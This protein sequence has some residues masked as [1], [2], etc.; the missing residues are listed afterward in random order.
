M[1]AVPQA[2]I[3]AGLLVCCNGHHALQQQQQQQQLP[4]EL[5]RLSHRGLQAAWASNRHSV[6]E[7]VTRRT[8]NVDQHRAIQ[9]AVRCAMDCAA[10]H[11]CAP[12]SRAVPGIP[13]MATLVRGH[14]MGAQHC[15]RADPFEHS[16][17]HAPGLH[18]TSWTDATS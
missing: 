4:G 9:H 16:M 11:L 7:V 18:G 8:S 17:A 5:Q 6:V 13:G 1:W 15:A 2:R 3:V 12:G 10:S 14:G